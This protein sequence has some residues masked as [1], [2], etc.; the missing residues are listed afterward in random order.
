LTFTEIEEDK[1]RPMEKPSAGLKLAQRLRHRRAMRI[2][3]SVPQI[4]HFG[5]C[6]FPFGGEDVGCELA[7]MCGDGKVVGR[8]ED[9]KVIEEVCGGGIRAKRILVL[10]EM[11]ECVDLVEVD[12]TLISRS[13]GQ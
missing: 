5:E 11:V 10:A 9:E 3:D 8:R 7:P 4:L 1:E 2:V 13:K 6:S 12:L